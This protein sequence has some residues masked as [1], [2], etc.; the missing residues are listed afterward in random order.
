MDIKKEKEK[1]IAARKDF[2][3]E[4]VSTLQPLEDLKIDEE[5]KP[6]LRAC[7]KLLRNPRAVEN[8]QELIGSCAT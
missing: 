8:L 3:E 5:F 4:E 2:T 6:F 1:F 7:M